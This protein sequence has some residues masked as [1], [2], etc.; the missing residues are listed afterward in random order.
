MARLGGDDRVLMPCAFLLG[1]VLLASCDALGRVLLAPAEIPAGAIT[2]FIGGPYLIWVVRQRRYSMTRMFRARV[3]R[4]DGRTI[5]VVQRRAHLSYCFTGCCCGRTERGYAAVPV[6]TF[7]D[8]WLRRKLRNV[9]HLTKA[10]CLGPARWR[11]SRAWCSTARAVWFH[12]VNTPWHVRLIYDYIETMV[13]R[14]SLRRAALGADR[15]RL[16]L[17]RLGCAAAGRNC[18]PPRRTQDESGAPATS[19]CCRTPTPICWRCKRARSALPADLDV[20]GVSL[21]RLQT[22]EQLSL[23][24]DGALAPAR[25]A[26][27]SSAWRARRRAGIRAAASVGDRAGGAP[28]RGERNGRAASGLRAGQHR[29]SWT[30]S[31]PYAPI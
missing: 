25:S 27:A 13:Q 15:V 26:R 17:L 19:R 11:T 30:W 28:G 2:A 21:V 3:V 9:V 14:R 12:S 16:Q 18:R 20:V 22:E 1:G 8:E 5:N 31:T 23:L 10:G 29:R 4:A 6:D 24:L 7:K